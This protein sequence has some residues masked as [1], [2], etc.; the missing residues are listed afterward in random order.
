MELRTKHKSSH[1]A[2][3]GFL[4]G[5]QFAYYYDNLDSTKRALLKLVNSDAEHVTVNKYTTEDLEI[6]NG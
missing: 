6:I 5:K 2:V 1:F 3:T 4:N